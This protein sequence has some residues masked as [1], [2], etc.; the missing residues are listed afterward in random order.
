MFESSP[1]ERRILEACLI[2]VTI[3][4]TLLVHRMSGNRMVVLNLFFLPVVLSGFFLGR[5]H[6][7][8]LAL[9]CVISAS[10]VAVFDF[11]GFNT[12]VS[13]LSTGLCVTVWGSVL[14]LTAILVGTLSD[15]RT[16][17]ARELHDAYVGVIEVLSGYLQGANPRLKALSLHVAEL[18][19]Q[20][21]AAMRL[22]PRQIDDIRVAALMQDIGRI[23]VTTKVISRAVDNLGA[24]GTQHYSFQGTD[25]VHSL[26]TVLRGAIPILMNQDQPWPSALPEN[27]ATPVIPIGAHIVRAVRTYATLTGQGL[28]G[29]LLSSEE[30]IFEMRRD[31]DAAYDQN[32]LDALEQATRSNQ[33]VAATA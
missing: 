18:C 2:V 33:P 11:D 7:G 24:K 16:A 4:L 19:Q 30:A 29:H 5:Y 22:T 12:V 10:F 32:V 21:A 1:R 15:D 25:L 28:D 9:L 20:V 6:A 8:V 3:G 13:P 23:E 14:C 27:A 31:R 17:Q 26:G